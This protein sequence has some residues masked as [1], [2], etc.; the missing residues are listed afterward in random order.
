MSYLFVPF[1]MTTDDLE[2]H[3]RDSSAIRGTLVL[4]LAWF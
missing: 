2:G 3:S 1:P 4:H